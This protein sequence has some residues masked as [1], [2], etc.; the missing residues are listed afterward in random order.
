MRQTLV[1]Q[2]VVTILGNLGCRSESAVPQLIELLKDG[3]P[4]GIREAAATALGKI[5]KEAKGAI[6]QLINVLSHSRANVAVQAVRALGGIGCADQRVRSALVNLWLSPTPAK[7]IQVQVAIALCKLKIDAQGLLRVLTTILVA[8]ADASLRKAAA[9]ALSWCSK[10]EQ[11]VVPALLT[12]ALNDK[13]EKVR[14]MAEAAL[15]HLSLSHDKAIFLCAKQLKDSSYAEAALRNSGQRAVPVLIKALGMAEPTIQMKAARTLGCLGE[16]AAEAVPALGKASH[17]KDVDVQLAAAKALWNITK[18]AELVVPVLV[19]L[20]AEKRAVGSDAG[21]AR[22]RYLQTVIE[23]LW[24]IG[25]PAK[26]AVPALR[27]LAKDKNRHVSES[28][29]S[30]LKEIARPLGDKVGL[31]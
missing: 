27:H 8:N 17:D 2:E 19:D 9:E 28:A 1:R 14:Q 24:R 5:G 18:N 6:D 22:R 25:P 26:A 13:D 3:I 30:A 12:A 16:L 10:N 31:R 15:A 4:D 29:L 21:E 23:A 11:D 7:N 20:L